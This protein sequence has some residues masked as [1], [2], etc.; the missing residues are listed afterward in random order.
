MS[1]SAKIQINSS[2]NCLFFAT[3]N[4]Y[5]LDFFHHSYLDLSFAVLLVI[6]EDEVVDE[7]D[8]VEE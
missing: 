8:E 4:K 2:N 6:A 5:F 7:A 3:C 1:F